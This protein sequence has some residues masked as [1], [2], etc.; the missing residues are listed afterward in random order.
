MEQNDVQHSL[1]MCTGPR[2]YTDAAGQGVPAA[3][4]DRAAPAG[5]AGRDAAVRATQVVSRFILASP[6]ASVG[7]IMTAGGLIGL[8]V[9]GL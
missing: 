8:V 1:S 4:V 2:A 6:W 5:S 7:V 9:A 3:D